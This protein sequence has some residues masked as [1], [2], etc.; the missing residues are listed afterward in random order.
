MGT[1]PKRASRSFSVSHSSIYRLVVLI[2]VLFS[3]LPKVTYARESSAAFTPDAISGEA[4]DLILGPQAPIASS[5]FD[6]TEVERGKFHGRNFPAT[7]PTGAELDN[8]ILTNYYDLGLGLAI[9]YRRT[10]D[11]E[12]LSLFRK[13][14]DSWW[15]EPH[16]KE[17]TV[18]TFDTF[19]HTPR[20]ASLG[21]LI[22]RALDGRPEMWDWINAYTRY[23]FDAWLKS[24]INDPQLYLG[25]RDGAFMLQYATWLAKVLPDTF[26]LQAGGTA[27]N[28]A[29][30]RAQYLADIEAISVNYFGRLQYADGSWRWDDPYYTDADGGQLKGVMQPF[31]IGLVLD[32]LIDVHEI[33]T[34][35]TVKT[36]IRNQVTKACR[37]L[38]SDGP[39]SRQRLTSLNVN[40][41]GFHYF[42]HGGTT[43]NPTKYENGDLPANWNPPYASDVQNQRQ[44]IG[45]LVAAYGWSYQRTGDSFFKAAG[46]DLWDSAYGPTD[47]IRNYMAGDGKS[48]N[49]N[50]RWAGSYLVW[51]GQ[52]S[53]PSPTPTPSP[54]ATPTPTPTPTATPTPTPTPTPS[55]TPQPT[56]PSVSITTP[57]NNSVY[58][59][60]T[61][62]T[63][64]AS[65]SSPSGSITK[66]DFYDGSQLIGTSTTSP[67]QVVLSNGAVGSHPLTAVARDNTGLSGSSDVV[68][69]KISKAL[70]GVRNNKRTSPG[71]SPG[72]LEANSFDSLVISLTQTYYDFTEERIMFTSSNTIERSLFAALLLAR[73]SAALARQSASAAI[74]NRLDKLDAYLEICEDLMVSGAVSSST[75]AHANHANA[76]LD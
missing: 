29:A 68:I 35:A 6:N 71:S 38:Y 62:I 34:N 63:I 76:S 14:E 11:P 48:Y 32:A 42:Y 65:A 4:G 47:G 67:Y 19:S 1:R 70:N 22:L 7:P 12:F 75:L 56:P 51:A 49:Q 55:P 53:N 23:Q 58:N 28:G 3:L 17:G 24:R 27:T 44:P 50:C 43:V 31:M 66:V 69:V 37:H 20:N 18:R 41:R 45:L 15:K 39:Y 33:T 64:G 2:L 16:I 5:W 36:S 46:D 72:N 8:Y 73:S 10:S 57:L 40:L 30:L 61:N 54:T 52:P 25:V 60:G 21:G 9:A 26:P 59:Y 74:D 13:V